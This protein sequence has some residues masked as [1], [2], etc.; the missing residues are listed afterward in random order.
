[1]AI[2]WPQNQLPNRLA[3]ILLQF[4][5][6]STCCES[7]TAHLCSNHYTVLKMTENTETQCTHPKNQLL[8]CLVAIVL[9]FKFCSTCIQH[10]NNNTRIVHV[11]N[12]FSNFKNMEVFTL[13]QW[14]TYYKSTS[15]Y[16]AVRT[17]K[18]APWW[19]LCSCCSWQK[20]TSQD[21]VTSTVKKSSL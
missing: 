19:M 3:T 9:H 1:M 12:Q 10:Y 21:K 5:L 2:A 4:K 13:K 20:D 14:H 11:W 6:C 7:R 18:V 16:A 8:N 15:T 17:P